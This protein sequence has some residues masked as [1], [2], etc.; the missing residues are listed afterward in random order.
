[1]R[2]F[3]VFLVSVL[4]ALVSVTPAVAQ[5]D[6]F[7][8][9]FDP[10]IQS[11][12]MGGA[13]AAV[14]WQDMPNVWINPSLV[15]FHRGIRYSYG[16]TKLLP[17]LADDVT[18]KSHQILIGGHGIGVEVSGKPIDDVGKIELDYGE[19][20]ITDIN[21]NVIGTIE[22]FEKASTF[23]VGVDLVALL[24]SFQEAKTGEPSVLRQRLSI[25]FGHT[26]K[27]LE[28]DFGFATG[29]L[30][31]KDVGALVRVAAL[32]QIGSTLRETSTDT[33]C[34]L[35]IAGGYSEQNY[36]EEASDTY[37]TD[38]DFTQYGASLRLTVA[39][40][41]SE[42]AFARDY[43]T[44]AIG[45]GVAWT[46]SDVGFGDDTNRFGGE[47]SIYDILFLR[48]GYIDDKLTDVHGATF[49]GGVALQYR[50]KYGARFDYARVPLSDLL[51]SHQNRYQVS[52]FV[53]PFR[54]FLEKPGEKL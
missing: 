47:V 9:I 33:R 11:A 43:G 31:V 41:S 44:P 8:T 42:G 6:G 34:R 35:E 30:D 29:E 37:Y 53:D 21:G 28:G 16:T 3:L 4:A 38:L 13:T 14:F 12:G 15:S 54:L 52:V 26:W 19:S 25:A 36:D 10:S 22:A 2:I 18:L 39:P 46:L 40:P 7:V 32:D 50:G 20:E 51:D 45:V 5:I 27:H 48:G 17:D 23:A 24:A 49:G 1:M